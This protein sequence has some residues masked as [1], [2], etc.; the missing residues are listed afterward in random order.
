MTVQKGHHMQ[1]VHHQLASLIRRTFHAKSEVGARAFII[2]V[3]LR[4]YKIAAEMNESWYQP[5]SHEIGDYEHH[6]HNFC[7]KTYS[8]P[9][10]PYI[11]KKITAKCTLKKATPTTPIS[12]SNRINILTGCASQEARR[13]QELP[14]NPANHPSV[15]PLAKQHK[16]FM[17]VGKMRKK[18]LQVT[19]DA[20]IYRNLNHHFIKYPC[21]MSKVGTNL[22][23]DLQMCAFLWCS[24]EITWWMA[25]GQI[26]VNNQ[27]LPLSGRWY[28]QIAQ[29]PWSV[30]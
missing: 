7:K 21:E 10:E 3:T 18:Q 11:S 15:W 13:Q 4:R 20:Q 12:N 6:S 26:H 28:A 16:E 24:S 23:R 9:P 19:K 5:N 17:G 2:T 29:V 27:P 22:V 25:Y 8:K 1:Q 30:K 14:S